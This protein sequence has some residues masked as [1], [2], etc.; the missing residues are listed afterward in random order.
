MPFCCLL[1]CNIGVCSYWNLR[2][3]LFGHSGHVDSIPFASFTD[4]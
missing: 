1:R 4:D 2:G 3:D